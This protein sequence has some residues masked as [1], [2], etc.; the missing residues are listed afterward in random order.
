MVSR[1][2]RSIAS[3]SR[4]RM[5]R[6]TGCEEWKMKVQGRYGS[7]EWKLGRVRMCNV[8]VMI[9]PSSIFCSLHASRDAPP[10]TLKPFESRPLGPLHRFLTTR[11]TVKPWIAIIYRQTPSF[12]PTSPEG[13]KGHKG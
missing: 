4:E 1:G 13:H 10:R 11:L 2:G 9:P 5:F 3:E 6:V 8:K 12:A 7:E